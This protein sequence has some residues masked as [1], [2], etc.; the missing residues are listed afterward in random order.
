MSRFRKYA[1]FIPQKD[2]VIKRFLRRWGGPC[3]NCRMREH[4]AGELTMRFFNASEEIGRLRG[5]LELAKKG[6]VTR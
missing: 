4:V 3:P 5:K 2:N 1:P 6:V